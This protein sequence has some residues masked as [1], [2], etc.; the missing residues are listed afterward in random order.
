[1]GGGGGGAIHFYVENSSFIRVGDF[2]F[3]KLSCAMT[4]HQWQAAN[5]HSRI[6]LSPALAAAKGPPR[7]TAC[8][9]TVLSLCWS[10]RGS[11]PRRRLRS[12]DK[13][14]VIHSSV[15]PVAGFVRL[16]PLRPNG[17]S[18]GG[19]TPIRSPLQHHGEP[20]AKFAGGPP[21]FISAHISMCTTVR[22]EGP[23]AGRVLHRSRPCRPAVFES[24]RGYMRE[25]AKTLGIENSR[26][27][28]PQAFS[29]AGELGPTW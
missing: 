15:A 14:P 18:R 5:R 23:P 8:Q 3:S 27:Q 24:L 1:V 13:L 28:G 17:G 20:N 22:P 11:F 12:H 9:C 4:W 21:L 10:N 6:G 19:G 26:W 25:K 16:P 2:R 29:T 7:P